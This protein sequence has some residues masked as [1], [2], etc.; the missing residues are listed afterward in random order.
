[1]GRPPIST[2]GFGIVWVSSRSRVPR[3][4]HRMTTLGAFTG[5]PYRARALSLLAAREARADLL[6]RLRDLVDDRARA[7]L[8][9]VALAHRHTEHAA[10]RVARCHGDPAGDPG[11]RGACPGRDGRG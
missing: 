9:A 7:A 6:R 1:M 3:P 11:H 10:A 2:S 4:P 8:E 5:A